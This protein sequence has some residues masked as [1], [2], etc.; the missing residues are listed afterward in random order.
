MRAVEKFDHRRGYRFSTYASWWVRQSMGRSIADKGTTIR[1]PVHLV[2]S[3]RKVQRATQQFVQSHGREP[4]DVDLAA[5]TGLDT[6]K[7]RTILMSG[8]RVLSLDAPVGADADAN[9]GDFVPDRTEPNPE[10]RV[11]RARC[12]TTTRGLLTRLTP[13]E[14]DVL[15]MRFGLD[16][17][18]EHTLEQIGQVLGLTRERIRQIEVQA[19]KKLKLPAEIARLQT[20][21]R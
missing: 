13:R 14:Q 3:R 16:E 2:E 21:L 11:A 1:L 17:T 6:K 18:P 9:I 19:L 8:G 20:Y 5:A 12:A 4:S 15:R 10:E 7:V